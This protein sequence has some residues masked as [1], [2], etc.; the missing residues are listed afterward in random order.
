MTYAYERAQEHRKEKK[1]TPE[2]SIVVDPATMPAAGVSSNM[3]TYNPQRT[4]RDKEMKRK[5]VDVSST[6]TH[7]HSYR[8]E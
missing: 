7:D 4:Y 1:K 8:N 6:R 2:M 3:S 5:D